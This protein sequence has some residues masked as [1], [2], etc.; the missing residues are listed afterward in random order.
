[1]KKSAT[2]VALFCMVLQGRRCGGAS[3]RVAKGERG[4]GMVLLKILD[5]MRDGGV[6]ERLRD[7]PNRHIRIHQILSR[8][9]SAE[10]VF[11]GDGRA[12]R[13]LLEEA[14]EVFLAYVAKLCEGGDGGVFKIMGVK[15]LDPR[16]NHRGGE[17]R[18]ALLGKAMKEL[19]QKHL[20]L[21]RRDAGVL[22]PS[23]RA[24]KALLQVRGVGEDH[25]IL[26][27]NEG[28]KILV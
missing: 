26:R 15:V 8:L 18:L 2:S 12:S 20:L 1:M 25:D 16:A 21:H 19:K 3:V 4:A 7:L 17:R 13:L 14:T 6:R 22:A 23:D 5:K 11:L 24:L 28:G 10:L 27:E 9:A